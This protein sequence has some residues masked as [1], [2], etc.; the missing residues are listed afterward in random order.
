MNKP[1]PT[2]DKPIDLIWLKDALAYL[3]NRDP[4]LTNKAI[5]KSF[6]VHASLISHVLSGR[7]KSSPLVKKL[8]KL[9]YDYK[10]HL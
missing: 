1:K 4:K 3:K 9:I 2:Q 10:P 8:K 6:K 5:A 7:G